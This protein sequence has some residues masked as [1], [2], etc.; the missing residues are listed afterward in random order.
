MMP[1][2]SLFQAKHYGW[3]KDFLQLAAVEYYYYRPTTYKAKISFIDAFTQ[4]RETLRPKQKGK[5]RM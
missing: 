3:W 4:Y 2:V 5:V 1:Y